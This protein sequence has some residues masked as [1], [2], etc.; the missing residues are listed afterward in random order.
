MLLT[1]MVELVQEKEEGKYFVC[2]EVY[3]EK[4][5]KSA[6]DD[7]IEHMGKEKSYQV[8]KVGN[9]VKMEHIR[10]SV[11]YGMLAAATALAA[12][13]IGRE[14]RLAKRFRHGVRK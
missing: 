12:W 8:E 10:D 6:G 14:R 11:F 1:Y 4:I 7:R 5:G 13:T 3:G 2:G 9:I